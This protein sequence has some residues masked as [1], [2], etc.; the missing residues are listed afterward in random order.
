MN[1]NTLNIFFPKGYCVFYCLLAYN[2]IQILVI[3]LD[4]L[5][6]HFCMYRFGGVNECAH[7]NGKLFPCTEMLLC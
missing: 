5:V 4:F 6:V 7:Y 3:M 2:L 1:C